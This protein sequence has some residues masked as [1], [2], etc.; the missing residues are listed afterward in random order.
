MREHSFYQWSISD[1]EK[2]FETSY[3][4]GLSQSAA[5]SRLA[6]SG[7][8]SFEKMK[9]ASIFGIFIRQFFNF[10]VLLLFVAGVISYFVDGLSQ[11]LVLFVIICVNVLLGFFQEVKAEKSL[12]A[13]KRSFQ[14]K[15]RVLRDQAVRIINSEDLVTGDVVIIETGDKIPA[16]LR[17][18]EEVSFR[19][20]ESAL[21]GESIPAS[22]HS[23]VL[24]DETPL[25]D[26]AN[27]A[28]A[29]TVAVAGHARGVVVGTGTDTE[30]G[31]VAELVEA[32][33][34][35][36]PLEKNVIYLA[37]VLSV[38]ALAVAIIIFVLG[39][40]EGQ[41]IWELLTFTIALLVSVVPE[42]L[43]TAITLA[44]AVGV[45]RMARKKAIVRRLAVIDTLGTID[46]IATDKTGTL[47]DNSLSIE[48]IVIFDREEAS[49]ID[50]N[51]KKQAGEAAD[52]LASALAV[53]NLDLSDKHSLVG[54]PVEVAIAEK[55]FSLSSFSLAQVKD[56]QRSL[57]IPFSSDNKYM[58]ALA[59]SSRGNILLAKGAP[60]KILSLCRLESGAKSKA[61]KIAEDLSKQGYK[62]IA[63][64]EKLTGRAESSALSGMTLRCYLAMV[65]EPSSGVREAIA[66]TIRAGIRPIVM[67]GDHP[68]TARFVANKIGLAVLDDEILTTE[69]LEKLSPK[70]LK[71]ALL[72][73]KVF[74]RVTPEDKIKL[75]RAMQSSGYSVVVTGDGVNDA[76][77][78]REAEVGI[79]MGVKGTDVAKDTAD[80]ILAD[81]KYGTIVS[82]I[83]YGRTIYDNIRNVSVF[84]ISV[85]LDQAGLVCLAFIFGLPLPFTTLQILWTNLVT[86]SAPA[87]ALSLERPSRSVLSEGPRSDQKSSMRDSIIYAAL[88]AVVS[89]VLVFSLYLWGLAI[90]PEKGRTIAFTFVVFLEFVYVFSIRSKKRIWQSPRS[91][92]ENG[93]L[94]WSLVI[95]GLLQ[96]GIFFGPFPRL[97]GITTLGVSE[98]AVLAVALIVTFFLIEVIR[99]VHDKRTSDADI[100][101]RREKS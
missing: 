58:A 66:Q 83:E 51:S 97:F 53:S 63:L 16:D 69:D 77:A 8:N 37:K 57:E 90:S 76:P 6:K 81:D 48:K 92:F 71:T 15:A 42:S 80:V 7:P 61:L 60:E 17:I 31:K 56:Y 45:S 74:A 75:V 52:L 89:V 19:V 12:S 47:T 99:Y 24:T 36:T 44:L 79:A 67:T 20:D 49:E 13:L 93:W 86:D 1:L 18:I 64:A 70:E 38:I 82:A 87:L 98:I 11:A 22:K 34:A 65:D 29:S 100:S 41:P 55:A 50:F 54:D 25:A 46:I 14:S 62:V 9:E 35:K 72:K 10:F 84:M 43:P 85:S 4:H 88:L 28:Y 23:A 59:H 5:R 21:T 68:E 3:D 32:K 2:H 33:E 96:V 39:Y 95:S 73:T 40:L 94:L 78:L 27:M 101:E 30:F 91:F 26:R